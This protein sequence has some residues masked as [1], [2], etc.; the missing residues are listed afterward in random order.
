MT[1]HR[2][3]YLTVE[4]ISH[5]LITQHLEKK[6]LPG[7]QRKLITQFSNAA[8]W[9]RDWLTKETDAAKCP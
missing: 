4:V 7:Y 8:W 6:N 5:S 1:I 3:D 2:G 9:A